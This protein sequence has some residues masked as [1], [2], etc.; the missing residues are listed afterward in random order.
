M[1]FAY[2]NRN[3]CVISIKF[4]SDFNTLDDQLVGN[5][6]ILKNPAARF[7]KGSSVQNAREEIKI[8]GTQNEP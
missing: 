2:P 4:Q 8:L 6:E 1:N 7:A 5:R 3:K